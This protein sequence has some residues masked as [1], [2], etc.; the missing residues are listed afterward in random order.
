MDVLVNLGPLVG[1]V[2]VVSVDAV[3]HHHVEEPEGGDEW[4]D[5]GVGGRQGKHQ[6]HPAVVEAEGELVEVGAPHR[7]RLGR[8]PG[9]QHA[10]GVHEQLGEAHQ[11]QR[12]ADEGRGDD[13]V[14]EERA[15][16]GKEYA[17]PQHLK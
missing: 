10:H 16:V 4:A 6:E 1:K 12:G 9:E 7:R 13:V 11:L 3:L 14:H 15:V 5:H 8:R 17:A 2:E